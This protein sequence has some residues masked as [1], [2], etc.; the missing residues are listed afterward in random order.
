M[1]ENMGVLK[2]YRG[3]TNM[4]FFHNAVKLRLWVTSY[5]L[6]DFGIKSRRRDIEF[7]KEEYNFTEDETNELQNILSSYNLN[8]GFLER[9]PAWF[10]D[11]ERDYILDIL[12]ELLKNIAIA[13]SIHIT[14]IEEY[15]LRRN[16]QDL[17]ICNCE[18]LFQEMQ[19]VIFVCHPDVEKYMKYVDV[20]E[21]EIYLLKGWRKSDNKLLV[22]LGLIKKKEEHE[23][24]EIKR[25]EE[26]LNE[27]IKPA[28]NKTKR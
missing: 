15:Y 2:K 26:V 13:N 21:R 6:R 23:K 8:N 24:N 17:A 4:E 25:K 11:K 18:D 28:N 19:Y 1:E 12:R 22:S 20:I 16:Y 7:L 10:I 5:M 27:E 9:F 14:N 3:I